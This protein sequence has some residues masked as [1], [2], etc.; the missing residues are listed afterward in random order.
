MA[1]RTTA[2]AV[3]AIIETDDSIDLTPFIEMANNV[4]TN[5][6][7]YAFGNVNKPIGYLDVQLELIER[8]LSAHY[9]AIRDPQ[10]TD[11][12]AGDV[13]QAYQGKTGYNFDATT[14][15]QQAMTVDYF[16]T[17]AAFQRRIKDGAPSRPGIVYLGKRHRNSWGDDCD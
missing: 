3:S 15:G 9:Y 14:Y 13:S 4:T 5:V 12:K 1:Y 2:A 16:G 6:C 8:W 17:L 11:E 7:Q 10:V